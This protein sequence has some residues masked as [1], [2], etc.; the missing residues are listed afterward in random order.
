MATWITLAREHADSLKGELERLEGD[1]DEE[2]RQAITGRLADLRV[3]YDLEPRSAAAEKSP[4]HRSGWWTGNDVNETWFALH[5]VEADIARLRPHLEDLI[6][7]AHTHVQADLPRKANSELTQQLKAAT[8]E[9]AKR[10]VALAAIA[11]SHRAEEAR[12]EGERQRQRGV[13]GIAGA[14]LVVAALAL[15]LQAFSEDPFIEPPTNG[16]TISTRLL[17]VLVMLFGSLGGLVSA[18][19]SLYVVDNVFT[20]TIWFDPR[21]MLTVTKVVCGLWMAVIGLL[22]VGSGLLVGTYTS[23]AS[24]LLLAFLFGYGQQA[25]TGFLDRK[26]GTMLAEPKA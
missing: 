9:G 10:N 17:L 18:L 19:F 3:A 24:A 25:V 15:V 20:D 5:E 6:M 8:S 14:L 22:A 26:V 11:R 13:L 4:R 21:P 7:S 1:V 2:Q 23:V 16:M 12:Y